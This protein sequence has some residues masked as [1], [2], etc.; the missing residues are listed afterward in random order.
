MNYILGTILESKITGVE[1]AQ[2]NRLKL[3]KQHG[4]SSKCVYVKWNPYSY[5]YAKQHQIE[6]DVFTMYDYFQKAI[7]YKKTKQVN[8]IQYWEKSCRYTLKFVENSNDVRIYDEEQFVMYAHFLDKQYHQLNYVNYFDHKRRKVK[9]E[10]Y[11]GRGFLSCSRILGEGQRIVL[12]NYYTPNGEIVIQKYFD[13]IKGK[14][15]LTKVI[16]NED[17]HQQF[18]DTEDELVQYFLHQLCKNNDQI[19]LD[20]PHELGNVIAGLNQSIPVIVV[21]H[22]THLSGAGNGIKSFYKT[23]FNN[24]TRYK[25]IVVSTEKQCQDISQYIENK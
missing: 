25:A 10:L 9:R 22:S 12:E 18:F 7:N 13:D 3:F 1:K 21:L 2:I 19:I 4:I 5:T 15:T 23:V 11:D 8:W 6:N 17:Q 24:L 20:R 14:N 16:L